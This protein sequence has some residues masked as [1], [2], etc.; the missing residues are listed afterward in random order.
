M[1]HFFHPSCPNLVSGFNRT[2]KL[3]LGTIYF[4]FFGQNRRVGKENLY[5]IAVGGTA[6][7]PLAALLSARG[8]RVK[9]SD[10]ALY[11]PMSELI[12]RAGIHV[13]PGFRPENVT[14][15]VDRVIIGNAVPRT[16]PEVQ[17]TL[18]RGLPYLSMPEAI[19]R[20]L[21]GGRHSVVVTGTHGKTTTSSLLAWL[22]MESG[23]DP[24]FLIGGELCNLGCGFRDGG[25]AHFLLEGDE[26]N[27]AF[28]DRGPKFLH[29]EPRTLLVNNIEFDHA[30]LY[31]DIAAVEDAFRRLIGIVPGDGVLVCNAD[32]ARA[33][34]LAA[35]A[36]CRVLSVSL[37]G[38][39][40]FSAGGVE[41]DSAGTAFTLLESGRP[42]ARI[43]SPLFGRHNLRN[44][45]MAS[46]SARSLGLTGEEIAAALPRFA[47]V[48]RRLEVLAER[49][50]ALFVD[51]FAHH[52]TAVEETL[53]AARLRW[54][55]RRLW[56]VFEPRSITAGRKFF[57]EA[58]GRAL[59]GADAVVLAPVFHAARFSPAELIDRGSIVRR[60]ASPDRLAFAPAALSEIEPLLLREVRTGDVVVLMS[61]GD[62]AGLRQKLAAS[63]PISPS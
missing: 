11:P 44:A 48:R 27:A 59:A 21:L 35:G 34:R 2:G 33:S 25:G 7:A 37:S 38:E 32:D 31:S 26:Y 63:S 12:A 49:D 41:V 10:L 56:A 58:Y 53:A 51:D 55:G 22:L 40:E 16:N 15:D 9:G 39:A 36:R 47:G 60:L 45:L 17:E 43:V 14:P 61:S 50:G 30:D 18:R 54:P 52:P 24:G 57:E 46:A 62:F 28:F 42:A 20:Y 23:R 29:Y 1:A 6:M 4:K 3:T 19:R 8:Y 13:L 5:F